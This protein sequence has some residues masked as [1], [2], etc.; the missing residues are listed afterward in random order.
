MIR[1]LITKVINWHVG[2]TM[3]ECIGDWQAAA[4]K[5]DQTVDH[6]QISSHDPLCS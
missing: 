6:R 2:G 4:G 1:V 5:V 3:N